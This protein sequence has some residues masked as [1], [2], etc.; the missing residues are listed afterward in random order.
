MRTY[1]ALT[2]QS[3]SK[4]AYSIIPIRD[5]D[6]CQIMK[7]RNEQMF[8]LRQK[9]PLTPADQE[10]YFN[11]V[12]AKLFEQDQPRQL[13]FSFLEN[14]IL[15]GY[16]GLVHINWLDKHAEVSFIMNTELEENRFEEIWEAYL[17]LIE[18]VAFSNLE[19]N[20]IS[21]YAY[22]LRPKLY[23][24]VE[25]LGYRKDA[26]LREHLLIEDNFINVVIHSKLK[27]EYI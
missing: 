24:V 13:L 26:V 20:K 7:W 27:T 2:R 21:T 12:V 9:E 4:D 22:D 10:A 3:F 14:D 16:G 11:N 19:L 15:I 25:S 23:F 5:E 17:K 6:S 8:H 1:K 18:E